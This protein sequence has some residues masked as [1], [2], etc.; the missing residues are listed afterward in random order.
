MMMKSVSTFKVK[1]GKIRAG[2]KDGRNF[3]N[4]KTFGDKNDGQLGIVNS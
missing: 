3:M 2:I 4:I 1:D